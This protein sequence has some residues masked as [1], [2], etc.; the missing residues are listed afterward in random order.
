MDVVKLPYACGVPQEKLRRLAAH[1]SGLPVGTPARWHDSDT[2]HQKGH[3]GAP[4]QPTTPLT[5]LPLRTPI[6]LQ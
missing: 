5:A 6:W 2:P 1:V 4:H 3:H